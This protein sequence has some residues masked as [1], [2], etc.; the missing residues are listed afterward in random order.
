MAICKEHCPF[1]PPLFCR[2]TCPWTLPQIFTSFTSGSGRTSMPCCPGSC[3]PAR[4]IFG[5]QKWRKSAHPSIQFLQ[6]LHVFSFAWINPKERIL[7][8]PRLIIC[9][10]VLMVDSDVETGSRVRETNLKVGQ[11]E[12]DLVSWRN[13]STSTSKVSKSFT[14]ATTRCSFKKY[15]QNLYNPQVPKCPPCLLQTVHKTHVEVRQGNVVDVLAK[16]IFKLLRAAICLTNPIQSNLI[17]SHLISSHPILSILICHYIILSCLI[18][19]SCQHAKNLNLYLSFFTCNATARS[20]WQLHWG[21]INFQRGKNTWK[22][23]TITGCPQN[24][25]NSVGVVECKEIKL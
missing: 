8:H 9:A 21:T 25:C 24:D 15:Q 20:P 22:A 12:I 11:V 10:H 17:L 2:S 19:L 5:H 18:Y 23:V 6:L 16:W 1:E 13:F 14:C 7:Q 3:R 4:C